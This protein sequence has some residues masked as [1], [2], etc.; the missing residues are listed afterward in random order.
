MCMDG[1]L[2]ISFTHKKSP[3][4]LFC[5]LLVS[6]AGNPRWNLNIDADEILPCRNLFSFQLLDQCNHYS[7]EV[8]LVDK[9]SHLEVYTT[10]EQNSCFYI[11]QSVHKA[12][13]EAHI[14]MKYGKNCLA[15]G[16]PCQTFK[17]CD[18]SHCTMVIPSVAKERCSKSISVRVALKPERLVWFKL[19]SLESK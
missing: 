16:F 14:N 12:L 5:A 3:R 8:V 18:G 19:S 15:L 10:C 6:L 2:C 7:G 13:D 9:N 11:Q 1:P 4:G 17:S